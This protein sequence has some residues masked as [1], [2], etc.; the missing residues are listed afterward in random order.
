[1]ID[2]PLDGRRTALLSVDFQRDIA[3]PDGKLAPKEA[4]ARQRYDDAIERAIKALGTARSLEMLIAHVR[5]V[6][7]PGHLGVN[8]HTRL[9]HYIVE[10]GALVKGDPGAEFLSEL[11]P[12]DGELV[13][14]KRMVSAFEGTDLD[15][16]LRA[17]DISTVVVMGLVTHFAVEGTVRS[18]ADRG[19]RVVTLSDCCASGDPARHRAALDVLEFLGPVIPVAS[20]AASTTLSGAS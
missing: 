11:S 14:E 4:D 7:Q 5:V 18:A 15:Q 13:V 9:G 1:M 19:F 10:Q 17:R 3:E 12:T 6:F 20:L 8:D 16:Q 2:P